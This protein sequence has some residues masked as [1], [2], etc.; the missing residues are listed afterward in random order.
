VPARAPQRAERSLH[1]ERTDK[2]STISCIFIE[3][4]V[5]LGERRTD[6]HDRAHMRAAR[7]LQSARRAGFLARIGLHNTQQEE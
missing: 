5:Y 2:A 4:C 1:F 3:R 7:P 6:K